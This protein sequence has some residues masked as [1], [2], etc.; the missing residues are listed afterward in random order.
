MEE[1]ELSLQDIDDKMKEIK[2]QLRETNSGSKKYFELILE[3]ENLEKRQGKMENSEDYYQEND[4]YMK[5]EFTL[6]GLWQF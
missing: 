6:G 4:I 3:L 1:D 5:K 2:D